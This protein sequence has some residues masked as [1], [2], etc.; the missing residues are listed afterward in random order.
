MR[1]QYPGLNL[2]REWIALPLTSRRTIRVMK[3]A[4]QKA[5]LG[6]D[7]GLTKSPVNRCRE[8]RSELLLLFADTV[9]GGV[10][11]ASDASCQ[12]IRRYFRA[13]WCQ[14]LFA[15]FGGGRLNHVA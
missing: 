3:P 10:H 1:R 11:N 15:C 9:L 2:P 12:V 5:K 14:P 7:E 4:V 13:F 6:R 8:T